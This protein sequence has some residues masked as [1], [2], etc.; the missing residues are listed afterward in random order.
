SVERDRGGQAGRDRSWQGTRE[1]GEAPRAAVLPH[2]GRNGCWCARAAR[3]CVA[4][5]RGGTAVSGIIS[6]VTP[7]RIGIIGGTFDPI[8]SG[9]L[10]VG[11]AAEAALGLT[12]MFVITAN[13]PPHRPQPFAS[14]FHRFAM[15][16]LAVAG[17]PGWR[18]SD[19]EL[20]SPT[21]SYTSQTLRK[22]H[23]RGFLPSEMFFII[24]AD[25][26]ADIGAWRDY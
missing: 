8:H 10:D 4:S 22:F 26:F 16:S 3:G 2:F 19:L 1:A 21:P 7:R 15:A 25:A 9:H 12:R 13:V 11:D 20:R 23:E 14:S 5:T 6:P 24:G 17:R 18:A